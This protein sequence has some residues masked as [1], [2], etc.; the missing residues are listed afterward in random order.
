[1]L[2]S[3]SSRSVA[4]LDPNGFLINLLAFLE[5]FDFSVRFVGGPR[6]VACVIASRTASA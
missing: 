6:F 1:M 3:I 2:N 5:I 4:I